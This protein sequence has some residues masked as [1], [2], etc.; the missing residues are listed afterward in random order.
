VAIVSLAS[1]YGCQ[2]QLT[3]MEDHLLAIL[4]SID[5]V[6][7]QL[8]SSGHMPEA[9]DIAVIEGAVT[10]ED[11]V[12]LLGRVR[13]TAG[14]VIAIGSCATT[15]GIPALARLGGLE[16]A[17]AIVYG[18]DARMAPGRL[19]PV[20]V[21]SI[22]DVDY[23]VP[24]CPVDPEEFVGVL[25][26]AMLGLADRPPADPLCAVCRTKEN[27]CHLERGVVCLGLVTRTG[28][29]ARCVTV[30]RPCTGCRGL[31]PEA[32]LPAAQAALRDK[33]LDPDELE[34]GLEL[35]NSGQKAIR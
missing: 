5:L 12:A 22:I 14:T 24:G 35:Y 6:Y 34:R 30:G 33:G 8:V 25:H 31:S 16:G 18:S 9:Y 21:S 29:G 1:D 17:Y 3:N 23:H 28:C 27:I 10:T 19:A 26:R 2:V 20:P 4:G 13:E 32:N 7:W 15:G 11:H